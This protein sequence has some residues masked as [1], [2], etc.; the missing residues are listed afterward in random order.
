M[1]Y[2]FYNELLLAIYFIRILDYGNDVRQKSKF[3]RFSYWSLKLGHKA[4]ET[5]RNTNNAFGPGA[6]NERTVDW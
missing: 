2:V 6:A 1:L 4:A 5:T 3:E